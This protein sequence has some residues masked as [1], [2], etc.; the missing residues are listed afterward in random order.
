MNRTL[1]WTY[2][3]KSSLN[4]KTLSARRL[5]RRTAAFRL[6]SFN[7]R[8]VMEQLSAEFLCLKGETYRRSK[9][10]IV[11]LFAP[12][13]KMLVVLSQT[14]ADWRMTLPLIEPFLFL[15]SFFFFAAS[16]KAGQHP[17][18]AASWFAKVGA[19]GG[20]VMCGTE[21]KKEDWSESSWTYKRTLMRISSLSSTCSHV[22][23]TCS[24]HWTWHFLQLSCRGIEREKGQNSST[25]ASALQLL[26]IRFQYVR[27]RGH[28]M[29]VYFSISRY[30]ASRGEVW[31]SLPMAR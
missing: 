17:A 26:I 6:F 23:P 5:S 24:F 12:P 11:R 31:S 4:A 13:Q 22:F 20:E 3:D 27:K 18:F 15:F 7:A 14:A 21:E 9:V 28:G 30:G 10:K 19:K 8:G 25:F 16:H 2:W 29:C 1:E